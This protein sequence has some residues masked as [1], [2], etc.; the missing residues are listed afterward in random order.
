MSAN[1]VQVENSGINIEK[2]CHDSGLNVKNCREQ[3]YDGAGNM[4]GKCNGAAAMIQTNMK[5]LL[6]SS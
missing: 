2:G 6:C 3:G 1:L 4:A 5:K